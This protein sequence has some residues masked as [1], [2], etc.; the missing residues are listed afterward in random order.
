VDG[1]DPP[2][3]FVDLAGAAGE[4]FDAELD[5][6]AGVVAVGF[7]AGAAVA[8]AA[9][10]ALLPE[11]DELADA[12]AG[13][14]SRL[15]R[16]FL[17]VEAV[18]SL[19]AAELAAGAADFD[20][21]ADASVESAAAF[22]ERDFFVVVPLEA[23]AVLEESAEASV[24]SAAAFFERDF[25]VV[26][27]EESAADFDV[28]ADAS[29]ESAAAF[30][31]RDF[32][33]VPVDESEPDADESPLASAVDFFFFDFVV[34]LADESLEFALESLDVSDA[35]FFFFFAFVVL[36]LESELAL[37]L[38]VSCALV[39]IAP[40]EINASTKPV[41][42]RAI[43]ALCHNVFMIVPL[44][45]P[46]TSTTYRPCAKQDERAAGHSRLAN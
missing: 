36:V 12:V 24:E 15:E 42:A 25:F 16:D 8:V 10:A 11:P 31:E 40:T 3:A 14:V 22:F 23:S 39:A 19:A 30:F 7:A 41:P 29:A 35:A 34:P 18:L 38:L 17:V 26:P 27:V 13:V 45:V 1:D 46:T 6:G 32:F 5:A 21:S 9:G 28:S 20:A 33:V 37:E 43:R 4:E 44:C 2:E